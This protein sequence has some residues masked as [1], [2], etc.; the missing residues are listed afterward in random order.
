MREPHASPKVD[1]DR[2]RVLEPKDRP[3][4]VWPTI[5]FRFCSKSCATQH[6]PVRDDTRNSIY[7]EITVLRLETSDQYGE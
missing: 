1:L 3:N 4:K 6:G 2:Y 7:G 5:R